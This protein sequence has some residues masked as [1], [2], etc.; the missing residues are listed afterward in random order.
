VTR[1]LI[2]G[3]TGF[4]G[5]WL[6]MWLASSGNHVCGFA[7]DPVP[8]AL[9]EAARVTEL[10][11]LDVRA[12]VRDAAAVVR[13]VERAAP[14]VIVHMAAQP[15]VRESYLSPRLTVETNV[16]GTLNVLEAARSVGGVRGHVVV[17]TDKVYRNDGR[18]QG[19]VEGDPLGGHDP[20]S[21]SKAMADL[22]AQSWALSLDGPPTAVARA[23]N[24]I[25]G[26]DVSPDRLVPDL[27]RSFEAGRVPELRHPEAL[28]PWQHV[29]D[30]LNGYLMLADVLVAGGSPASPGE[31]WNFGPDLPLV[32]VA[33]LSALVAALWG[34]APAPRQAG[35][36]EFRESSVL[37]LDSTK[38][39]RELG[40]ESLL[41][42]DVAVE[43]TVEWYR[44]VHDGADARDQTLRQL[45][46][47]RELASARPALTR[48]STPAP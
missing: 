34:G 10:L 40:W 39:R 22:L 43:W 18:T 24:V 27:V 42:F 38:A 47:Y 31:P 7:L 25:G 4:K 1:Y 9:F 23:G 20:Y 12:D 46:R 6:A 5:A 8:G 11:E 13:A 29:L 15:L 21:A 3:H 36:S 48:R 16:L 32:T 26:G 35:P 28:R 17:T 44:A 2:T 37:S 30:C 14:E 33:D 19:Y 45:E 41:S